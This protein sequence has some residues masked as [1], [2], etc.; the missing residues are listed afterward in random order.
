MS[1]QESIDDNDD[2][3]KG[4]NEAGKLCFSSIDK[5]AGVLDKEVAASGFSKKDDE[6]IQRVWCFFCFMVHC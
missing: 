4:R 6:D 3:D 2:S 5:S 1:F